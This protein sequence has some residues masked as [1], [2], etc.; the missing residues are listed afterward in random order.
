MFN[1]CQGQ[2]LLNQDAALLSSNLLNIVKNTC[3]AGLLFHKTLEFFG[4]ESV[5][6]GFVLFLPLFVFQLHG[7]REIL[8]SIPVV[9]FGL[10]KQL[11]SESA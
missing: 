5:E 8:K 6:E 3:F 11:Q 4:E 9:F 1:A 7:I 2:L 10:C